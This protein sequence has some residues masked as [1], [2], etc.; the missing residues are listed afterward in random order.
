[1]VLYCEVK[2]NV[3][4]FNKSSPFLV[5][6]LHYAVVLGPFTLSKRNGAVGFM[7]E[8]AARND[9]IKRRDSGGGTATFEFINF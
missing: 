3:S 5:I 9:T 2:I 4:K 1:M 7:A 6:Y 8:T